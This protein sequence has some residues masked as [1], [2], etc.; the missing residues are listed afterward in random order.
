MAVLGHSRT[1][2]EAE[3]RK[4]DLR[5]VRLPIAILAVNHLGLLGMQPKVAL[6]KACLK[7]SSGTIRKEVRSR[8]LS[9]HLQAS[10]CK[11]MATDFELWK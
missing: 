9:Q 8:H 4:L 10:Y 3:K 1:E 11:W 2:S 6:A 5:I 7:G